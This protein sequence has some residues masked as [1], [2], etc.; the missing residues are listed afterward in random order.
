MRQARRTR[1]DVTEKTCSK[2]WKTMPMNKFNT[3]TGN[4]DGK[5]YLCAMCQSQRMKEYRTRKAQEL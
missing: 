1:F 3:K 4:R 5:E 2:C